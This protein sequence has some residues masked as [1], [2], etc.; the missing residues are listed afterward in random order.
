MVETLARI[1]EHGYGQGTAVGDLDDD[2][3]DDLY[4]TNV[5][6]NRLHRNL[7][8]GTFEDITAAT[9]VAVGLWSTSAAWGDLDGD[10]DLDL[11]VCNYTRYDP[12]HPIP[13]VDKNGVSTIC[14]PQRV[15]PEPDYCYENLGNGQF[16]EVSHQWGL[17]GPG[18]KALGV[19]I[20]DLNGD[21]RTDVFVANDTTAN[22]LFV[23]Q[24]A[25][26][27]RESA[28]M[29]GTA[30]GALGEK[31][32]NM[33]VGLADYDDNGLPDLYITHFT[34]ETNTLYQNLG[35][36]GFHDASAATGMRDLTLPRLGFGTVM[37]D[38]NADGRCDIVVTNGH[39][40]P[41]NTDGDG[42]EMSPQLFSFDGMKWRD[43]SAEA[44]PYFA[45]R[46]VG[47][48]LA[49][50][51][52]DGDGDLDLAVVHQNLPTALL[53]NKSERGHWL[54]VSLL[55]S[56]SN[57]RGIGVNAVLRCGARRHVQ[58]MAGGTSYL[59]THQPLLAF[60]LGDSG[61]PCELELSW[62]SGQRDSVAI[63]SPD[64][65]IEVRE[66]GN[67]RLTTGVD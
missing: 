45:G 11:Y 39:I 47:R 43:G 64:V 14:H 46:Y 55:G 13:C 66:G 30:F 3:F 67:W 62:P 42:Y 16:Q 63:T 57:R 50:A 61:G 34:S 49:S 37:G 10:L 65:A 28:I 54:N 52:I 53:R 38:L 41:L 59:A 25:G 12:Y 35:P 15:A 31:M 56:A 40:D 36:Q 20:A 29:L 7:G 33:G 60:S 22:F 44:G 23:G 48:G 17:Q 26:G 9:G 8:D 2:G 4:V 24:D 1:D 51:D 19:V 58:Q 32:A 6:G 5:G 18:N 21:G 27:Y